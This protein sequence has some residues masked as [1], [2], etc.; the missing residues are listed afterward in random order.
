[1]LSTSEQFSHAAKSMIE[2]QF[3]ALSNLTHA[4][5]EASVNLI[6]LNVEMA[7]TG[8]AAQTVAAQQMLSAR[9]GK[10]FTAHATSH[11]QQSVERALAYGRQLAGIAAGAHTQFSRLA[12]SGINDSRRHAAQLVDAAHAAPGGGMYL[13]NFIKSAFDTAHA[14]QQA[15][16]GFVERSGAQQDSTQTTQ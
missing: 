13:N 10:E 3:A 7:K 9:D 15:A 8:M 16:A 6:G 4:G 14:G 1:M 12:E 11:A 2:T 5:F